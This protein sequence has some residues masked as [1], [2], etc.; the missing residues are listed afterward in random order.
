[1]YSFFSL[2]VMFHL[3]FKDI[4]VYAN[5]TTN[6]SYGCTMTAGRSGSGTQVTHLDGCSWIVSAQ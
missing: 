6:Q 4:F 2:K 3:A 1:M 5:L